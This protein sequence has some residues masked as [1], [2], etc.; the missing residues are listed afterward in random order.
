MFFMS[1]LNV[2]ATSE[3]LLCFGSTGQ[4]LCGYIYQYGNGDIMNKKD[5]QIRW[6]ILIEI[7]ADLIHTKTSNVSLK[8]YFAVKIF[9]IYELSVVSCFPGKVPCM[10]TAS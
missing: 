3:N 6:F 8:H 9:I 7:K 10:P 2:M 1:A 5:V 4:S